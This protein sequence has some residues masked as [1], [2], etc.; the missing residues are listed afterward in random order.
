MTSQRATLV[1]LS[2]I[3]LWSTSVGLIRRLTE[4]LG[5]L[6]GAAMIYSSSA[7]CL[8]LFNG[9][10]PIRNQSK[11][12]LLLGGALFVCYEIF[13]SLAIGFATNRMQAMELG[14]V[15]YLWPCL[16]ILFAI[17]INQQ[18]SRF[19]LWPGIALSLAGI[20]WI[21]KGDGVWSLSLMWRNI[22]ANPVAYGLA[23]AAAI[24]WALYC[25]VSRRFGGGKSGISLFFVAVSAVLWRQYLFSEEP[26]LSFSL[27]TVLELLFI[28]GSTALSYMA[29][30]IGIQRGNLTL[31]ATASY[32]TPMLSALLS[33][34]WLN[35]IPTFSFWQGVF[36]ITVGSLLSWLATR[37]S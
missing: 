6:G 25:N 3:L 24:V 9:F 12:Y 11:I 23:F 10:P 34:L 28:A 32:F 4:S 5:P 36:M 33:A 7:L 16:T 18:K 29:W 26:V 21:M 19:F 13:F 31:L 2:A 20:V 22:I 37:S 8:I 1:G 30:D 27:T 14:M 17:V 15:N 35:I